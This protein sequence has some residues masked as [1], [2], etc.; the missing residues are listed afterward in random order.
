MLPS[1]YGDI[2]LWFKKYE[3]DEQV[4]VALFDYCFNKS[5]LHKNYIQTVAE[6]WSNSKIK[7]YF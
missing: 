7:T 5:A 6:A 2:D 4:M 3:F 1:W